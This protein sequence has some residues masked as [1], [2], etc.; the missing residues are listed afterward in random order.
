MKSSL[1]TLIALLTATITYAQS[2]EEQKE[3]Y[4]S[5]YSFEKAKEFEKKGE[6]EKAMWFYINLFPDDKQR[7]VDSV[8]NIAAEFGNTGM[9]HLVKKSFATYASFDPAVTNGTFESGQQRI[10]MRKIKEK[11]KW[12]DELISKFNETNKTDSVH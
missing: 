12:G 5:K 11:N 6:F 2:K 8:K 4:P 7:V 9:S 10:D 1:F 3:I